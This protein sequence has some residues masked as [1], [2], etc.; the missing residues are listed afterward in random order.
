MAEIAGWALFNAGNFKASRRFN[1]EALFL[2]RLC[3]DKSIEL[4]TLQNRAMLSGWSGRPRE[5]LAIAASVLEARRL[6]PRV[7][8]I[9]R[10]REAQGLAGSGYASESSRA[11]ERARSLL[12]ESTP[13]NTPHW[14]WWITEREIDRQQG[15]ALQEYGEVR[16]AIPVL[17]NAMEDTPVAQVGYRNVA[18]VRLLDCLLRER[19]WSAAEKEALRV[20]SA[21]GEMSSLVSLNILSSVVRKH[22]E[23]PEVPMGVRDALQGISKALDEDFYEL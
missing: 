14:A 21:V 23:L 20:L 11:F 6:T 15:R 8:A 17:E 5:E 12:T 4:I 10:A 13:D 16:K 1:Q 18:A 19:S 9:F 7:E 22:A 2:A 3:G